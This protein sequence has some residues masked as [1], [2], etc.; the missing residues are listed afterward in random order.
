VRIAFVVLAMIFAL[1]APVSSQQPNAVGGQNGSQQT[2]T[3][4]SPESSS[5]QPATT[6]FAPGYRVDRGTYRAIC[7]SPK[8]REHADL[9]QQWRVA[10]TAEVQLIWTVLGFGALLGTL[11]ATFFT[12]RAARQTVE[13]MERTAERQLRAYVSILSG[14]IEVIRTE[15][16]RQFLR[17]FITFQNSGQTPG[18][19]FRTRSNLLIVDPT[20]IPDH[21]IMPGDAASVIGPSAKADIS[22]VLGPITDQ[23]L[24]DIRGG[25]SR[26]VFWGR[27]EYVDAFDRPR[28]FLFR[29]RNGRLQADGKSWPIQP[30]GEYV[31]N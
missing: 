7:D 8:D 11:A 3:K 1:V 15:N 27:V 26:I 16:D 14:H 4:D 13:T 22:P 12:A 18:Y 17:G 19:Q 2:G 31:A 5:R 20:F 23:Q 21:E 28:H 6:H 10:E 24:S 30:L 25:K 29:E 9:C